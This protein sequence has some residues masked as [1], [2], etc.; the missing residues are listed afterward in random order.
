[1]LPLSYLHLQEMYTFFLPRLQ[2]Q[3]FF[4]S[5]TFRKFERKREKKVS[6]LSTIKPFLSARS[7]GYAARK[8]ISF[9]S[10]EIAAPLH[11]STVFEQIDLDTVLLR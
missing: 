7:G 6:K 4:L 8:S 5:S 1:M 3:D 10:D 11:E 2:E 9:V